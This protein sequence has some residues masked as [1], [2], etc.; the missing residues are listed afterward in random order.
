MSLLGNRLKGR[1]CRSPCGQVEQRVEVDLEVGD[2]LADA[3]GLEHPGIDLARRA[4]TGVSPT[5]IRAARVGWKPGHLAVLDASAGDGELLG[6]E[7]P[8]V[9]RLGGVAPGE[10][11]AEALALV[12]EVG[13]GRRRPVEGVADLEEADAV[14]AVRPVVGDRAD[15]TGQQRGAQHRLLGHE[16]VG[17]RDAVV[18]QAAG[19]QLAGREERHRHGLGEAAADEERPQAAALG[20]AR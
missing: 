17:D 15:Q 3:V 7:L 14:V 1:N 4:P 11:R 18:G 6:D 20:L 5:R 2:P 13:V 16:R 9:D 8:Q 12:G 10:H 19:G